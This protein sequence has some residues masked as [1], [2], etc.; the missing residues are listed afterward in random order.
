MTA[1]TKRDHQCED[2]FARH[3]MMHDHLPLASA[4]SIADS[5]AIAVT[6]KNRLP[7]PAKVFCVLPLQ[8]VARAKAVGENLFSPARTVQRSLD[9]SVANVMLGRTES[10]TMLDSS[11]LEFEA[12]TE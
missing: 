6:L 2:R 5:A 9:G 12:F 3:P 4:R 7:Q 10:D 1:R 11:S 8:G